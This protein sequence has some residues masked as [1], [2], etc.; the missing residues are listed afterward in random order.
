MRVPSALLAAGAAVSLAVAPASAAPGRDA[1]LRPGVGAGKLRL[2][3][4]FAQ[5]RAVLGTP[6]RARFRQ[7][8]GFRGEYVQY[9]WGRDA[10]WEVGVVGERPTTARV[11]LIRTWRP[12]RT[13]VG[14]GV[15]S[16]HVALQRRLGARCYRQ[17]VG[18]AIYAPHRDFVVCYLGT[19]GKQPITYFG[20]RT[21]CTLPRDR[22]SAECPSDKRRYRASDVTIVSKLGQRILGGRCGF[23]RLHTAGCD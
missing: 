13:R 3:M 4:T 7:R 19:E 14:V 16:T 11:V 21:E 12:E 22:Y 15:G 18:P 20:L 23:E 5:V 10:D 1:L 9:V 6:A 17:L 8:Y 2:G